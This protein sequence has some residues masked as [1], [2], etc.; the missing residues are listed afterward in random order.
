MR[1]VAAGSLWPAKGGKGQLEETLLK[2]V[3]DAEEPHVVKVRVVGMYGKQ[4][5]FLL[6]AAR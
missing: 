6:A 1:R 3:S 2:N 5:C 4:V